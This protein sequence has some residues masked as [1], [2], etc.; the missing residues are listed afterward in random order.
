VEYEQRDEA[1]VN[2]SAA[3]ISSIRK[4]ASWCALALLGAA[5]AVPALGSGGTFVSESDS[6][7][8]GHFRFYGHWERVRNA[9]DGRLNGSSSRT[10]S[11]GAA[12]TFTFTGRTVR[13]YGVRGPG[14]GSGILTIDGRR[15]PDLD[16][17]APRKM[18]RVVLFSSPVLE[19]GSHVLTI[20]AEGDRRDARHRSSYVNLSGAWFQ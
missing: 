16:F 10:D 8:G 3:S 12:V 1:F 14:G 5:L 19:F 2:L 6:G 15:Y 13:L 11:P 7:P 20:A 18:P 17:F 4:P 9:T